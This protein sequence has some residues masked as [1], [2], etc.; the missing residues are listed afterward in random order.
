MRAIWRGRDE[1]Q[2]KTDEDDAM[3][4]F[5][6]GQ[7]IHVNMRNK[8]TVNFLANSICEFDLFHGQFLLESTQA[9]CSCWKNYA[10]FQN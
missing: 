6:T 4:F 3:K 10:E 2:L 8:M 7:T 5:Q 1:T 9:V